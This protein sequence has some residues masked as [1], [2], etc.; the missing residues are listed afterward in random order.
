MS[1]TYSPAI[2]GTDDCDFDLEDQRELHIYRH[3]NGWAID[4]V[5]PNSAT[6]CPIFFNNTGKLPLANRLLAD[7]HYCIKHITDPE[8]YPYRQTFM[9]VA[10]ELDCWQEKFGDEKTNLPIPKF[11]FNGDVTRFI[12]DSSSID[13]DS[14]L[15]IYIGGNG[16]WYISTAPGN[17]NDI[18]AVRLATSGGVSTKYPLLCNCIAD[19]NRAIS[20]PSLYQE[21]FPELNEMMEAVSVWQ[22]KYPDKRF[23]LLLSRIEDKQTCDFSQSN[24]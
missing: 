23:N 19:L 22:N 3:S 18:R 8:N 20:T 21:A 15:E 10:E 14:Y 7:A 2:C 17:Q 13:G 9:E 24:L 5:P 11:D 16:D 12:T 1:T 6:K 4:S